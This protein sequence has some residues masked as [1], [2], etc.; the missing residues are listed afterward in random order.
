MPINNKYYALVNVINTEENYKK[1][2]ILHKRIIS[3]T[4]AGAAL[5]IKDHPMYKFIWVEFNKDTQ[6]YNKGYEIF[7]SECTF[8][9]EVTI[10]LARIGISMIPLSTTVVRLSAKVSIQVRG[11]FQYRA[12][13]VI[14]TSDIVDSNC[15]PV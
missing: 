12:F 1:T 3:P 8:V 14:E 5:L 7:V 4:S 11:L 6:V 15:V 2:A 13:A 10:P 9:E